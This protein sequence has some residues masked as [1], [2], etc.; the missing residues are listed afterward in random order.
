VCTSFILTLL[1][2][3]GSCIWIAVIV[4]YMAEVESLLLFCAVRNPEIAS[5]PKLKVEVRANLLV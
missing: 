1:M 5:G 4:C 3:Q 2:E